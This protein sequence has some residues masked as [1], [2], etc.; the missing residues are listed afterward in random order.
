MKVHERSPDKTDFLFFFNDVLGLGGLFG[1]MF[2]F[3]TCSVKSRGSKNLGG[4][5]PKD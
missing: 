1:N 2:F 3:I 5:W 4:N